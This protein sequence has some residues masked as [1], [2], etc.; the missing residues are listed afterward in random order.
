MK[1]RVTLTLLLLAGLC[2]STAACPALAGNEDQISQSA[3]STDGWNGIPWGA[4]HSAVKSAFPAVG[5]LEPIQEKSNHSFKS[6]LNGFRLG[7]S[8]YVV[9]FFFDSSRAL[10][11]VV[12]RWDKQGENPADSLFQALSAKYGQPFNRPIG[13]VVQ[14]KVWISGGTEISLIVISSV[15]PSADGVTLS[16]SRNRLAG[17]I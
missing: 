15:S 1:I 2:I 10:S 6:S 14:R 8:S 17:G 4:T 5:S 13:S 3:S 16:Y 12:L 9:D 11:S 7:D